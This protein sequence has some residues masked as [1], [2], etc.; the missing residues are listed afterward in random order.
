MLHFRKMEG[1]PSRTNRSCYEFFFFTCSNTAIL[2][3]IVKAVFLTRNKIISYIRKNWQVFKPQLQTLSKHSKNQIH[4]RVELFH[5]RHTTEYSSIIAPFLGSTGISGRRGK[6]RSRKNEVT[7][8]EKFNTYHNWSIQCL[9]HSLQSTD[10]DN[11]ES[12]HTVCICVLKLVDILK[13]YS[14]YSIN[15]VNVTSKNLTS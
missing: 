3:F 14:K 1:V 5:D 13:L 6:C 2:H 8:K 10:V 9:N 7:S 11:E 12:V 4:K 15:I